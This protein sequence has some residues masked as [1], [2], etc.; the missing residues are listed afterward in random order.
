[1]RSRTL[2]AHSGDTL[3]TRDLDGNPF[4]EPTRQLSFIR[5]VTGGRFTALLLPTQVDGVSRWQFF[6]LNDGTRR[7]DAINVERAEDGLFNIAGTQ[8]FTSPD[9]KYASSVLER[10]PGTDPFT[11]QPLVPVPLATD[12]AG[13][14]LRLN[15]STLVDLGTAAALQPQ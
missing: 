14:A 1:S 12:R 15:G 2:A 10:E 3:G 11:K 13:T 8:L 9:P 6:A 5:N 4:H 7:I